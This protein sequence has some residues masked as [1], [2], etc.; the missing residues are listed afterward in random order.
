M[1][2]WPCY[3][4]SATKFAKMISRLASR[5]QRRLMVDS[6]YFS[7]RGRDGGAADTVAPAGSGLEMVVIAR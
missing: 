7:K 6:F 3:S 1:R 5:P 2:L 4:A